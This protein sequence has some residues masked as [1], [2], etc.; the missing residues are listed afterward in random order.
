MK[1]ESDS[2]LLIFFAGLLMLSI[3][4]FLLAKIVTVYISFLNGKSFGMNTGIAFMPLFIGI[5]WRF[6]KPESSIAKKVILIGAIIILVSILL[7]TKTFLRHTG[8][9]DYILIIGLIAV[10]SGLLFRVLNRRKNN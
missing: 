6:I 2:D 8:V 3:G 4:L 7:S 10:G 5:I 9:F 1:K